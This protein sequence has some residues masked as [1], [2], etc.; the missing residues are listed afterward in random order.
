MSDQPNPPT[1]EQYYDYLVRLN[2][3]LGQIRALVGEIASHSSTGIALPDEFEDALGT[4]RS[5]VAAAV[6]ASIDFAPGV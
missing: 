6:A 3:H 2:K 4:I 5:V 1:K